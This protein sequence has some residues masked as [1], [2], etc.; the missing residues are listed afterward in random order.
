MV[1]AAQDRACEHRAEREEPPGVSQLVGAHE[2]PEP[3]RQP[4]GL[5]QLPDTD[6]QGERHEAAAL[7]QGRAGEGAALRARR[8]P[9][10]PPRA[11][12]RE[13]EVQDGQHVGNEHR[14]AREKQGEQPVEGFD[15]K[16]VHPI[17]EVHER[18]VEPATRE[19]LGAHPPQGPQM[20]DGVGLR[21]PDRREAGAQQHRPAREDREPEREQ[22]QTDARAHH[23]RG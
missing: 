15:R 9:P 17:W 23:A 6:M 10:E 5:P 13:G 2:A 20:F 18:G 4:P 8:E 21:R 12:A 7:E 1:E 14:L 22:D 3:E 11:H 19:G 16:E